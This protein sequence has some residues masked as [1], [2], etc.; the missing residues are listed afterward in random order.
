LVITSRVLLEIVSAVLKGPSSA[1]K[2]YLLHETLEYFPREAYLLLTGM[3][4]RALAYGDDPLSHRM[5]VLAEAAGAEAGYQSY[6]IRTLLSEGHLAYQTVEKTAEGMRART[7]TREG[8]TGL[9]ITTTAVKLHP[10]NETRL[11]SLTID[12]AP[13]HTRAVL[14][15]RA[16]NQQVPPVPE[17]WLRLQEW[18]ALTESVVQ[19][20]FAK[21]L[22][23]RIPPVATRL[24]RDFNALL[25]LI[26]AHAVLHQTNRPRNSD[27]AIVATA[28]DYRAIWDLVADLMAEG[29]GAAVPGPVRD[30]VEAVRRLTS[31]GSSISVTALAKELKL[32]PSTT[33]RRVA[34]AELLG[35]LTATKEGRSKRLM[36]GTP[37]PSDQTVLPHPDALFPAGVI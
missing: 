10:E 19:I 1:G 15:G 12:D 20:P 18:L 36:I 3:S 14:I 37:V 11:L 28:P 31:G 23:E 24:R 32:D 13:E 22:A 21:E 17:E 5:L 29:V 16:E 8:P 33:S 30:T 4:E 6:L 25:G 2:S 27:G 7:I 35:Y 26:A 34:R 9:L